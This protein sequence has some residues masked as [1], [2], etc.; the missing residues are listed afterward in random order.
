MNKYIKFIVFLLYISSTSVHSQSP[1]SA[2]LKQRNNQVYLEFG[3]SSLIYGLQYERIFWRPGKLALAASSGIIPAS[4]SGNGFLKEPGF[5]LELKLLAC[6]SRH[7]RM[8]FGLSSIYFIYEMDPVLR[9]YARFR[10]VLRDRL[11]YFG[12][13]GY[14]YTARNGFVFRA[15]I[16]P[17]HTHRLFTNPQYM[18]WGGLSLGYSF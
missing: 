18:F 13:I 11:I 16:T 15:A 2:Q 14:R 17:F 3:A 10:D 7:H 4:P 6:A 5:P 9:K 1:D 12:R 8:E